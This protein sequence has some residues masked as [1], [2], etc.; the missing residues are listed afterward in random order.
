VDYIGKPEGWGL[1]QR[2]IYTA[3]RYH[4]PADKIL[5]DWDMSGAA[6]DAQLYFLVGYRV[7]N[8]SRMPEWKP[9]AEFKAIR[10]N[11]LKAAG[12]AP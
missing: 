6:Q 9:G 3:E 1:E 12:I 8:D 10:D 4:K 7:A 2:K 11:S 5:P